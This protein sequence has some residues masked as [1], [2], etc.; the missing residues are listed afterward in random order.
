MDLYHTIVTLWKKLTTQRIREPGTA[1]E[2]WGKWYKN[3]L[4]PSELLDVNGRHLGFTF[5]IDRMTELVLP[6]D[7][8]I[9]H[10]LRLLF[11][12]HGSMSEIALQVAAKI[13]SCIMAFNDCL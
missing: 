13:A 3:C 10:S 5:L 8:Y 9:A 12:E 7:I 1:W 2:S 11:K 4:R 6:P